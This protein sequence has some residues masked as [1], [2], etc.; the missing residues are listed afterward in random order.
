VFGFIVSN[1]AK[2]G[3]TPEWGGCSLSY[4]TDQST[5]GQYYLSPPGSS[6]YGDAAFGREFTV[7]PVSKEAQDDATAKKLW[8]IS[9]RLV[10]ITA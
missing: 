10:G 2:V 3:E 4:M 1:V 9:E 6:K 7:S 5:R 8:E